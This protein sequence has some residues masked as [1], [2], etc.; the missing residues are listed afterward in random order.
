MGANNI[1]L[2][3]MEA[4]HEQ[5][6][7]FD[8]LD[9][10]FLDKE[11]VDQLNWGEL[12]GACH[13]NELKTYQRLW[14]VLKPADAGNHLEDI[15]DLVEGLRQ[16][17][18]DSAHRIASMSEHR[19]VREHA[20][21]FNG[22]RDLAK[23]VHRNAVAVKSRIQHVHA[24]IHSMVASPH[25]KSML[26]NNVDSR[27]VE[28]FERIPSYQDLFGSLDYLQGGDV[29]SIFSPAAY[30]LDLM[31]IT[32]EYITD[33]NTH[34][35]SDNIQDGYKLQDRR[36]DL[37]EIKLNSKNTNAPLPILQ[38]V[39]SVLER[40]IEQELKV[41]SGVA[42]AGSDSSITLAEDASAVDDAYKDMLIMITGG[43][44][45]AQTR[46]MAGYSGSSKVASVSEKWDVTPDH[47]SRY[48]IA[49]KTYSTLAAA[50]YPFNL[51]FN[52]PLAQI[53]KYLD[54]LEVTLANILE[55]FNAPVTGGFAWGGAETTIILGDNASTVKDYYNTMQLALTGGTGAG[56]IRG[57]TAYNESTREAAV[58]KP[59][60]IK[61]DTTTR[62]QIM[63]RLGSSREYLGLSTEQYRNLITVQDTGEKLGPFFGYQTIDLNTLARVDNFLKRTGLSRDQL[64]ELLTQNLS[65]QEL[66]S[67]LANDFF[68]NKTGEG[69]P[70][71]QIVVDDSDQKNPFYKIA[72][73][74][75]KRLDRLNRFIRL[76]QELNWSFAPLNWAMVSTNA[77]EITEQAI[78]AIAGI[79]R[80]QSSTGLDVEELCAFW[81]DLKTMGKGDGLYPQDLF[82]RVFNS[83]VLLDG[84]DPYTSTDKIPFDT[85]GSRYLT[86]KISD[87]TG[88][89]AIIRGRLLGALR[90][91]NNDLTTM[92]M[93]VLALTG[94]PG[95]SLDLTLSNLTWL[96]RLSKVASIFKMTVDQYLLLLGLIYYP[97]SSYLK[98][99]VHSLGFT[100]DDIIYQRELVDWLNKIPLTLYEILYILK[101]EQSN[102]F[103][104]GY[105]TGDIAPFIENLAVISEGSRLNYNGFIY[106][107]IDAEQS[108]AI[109]KEL[110]DN[111]FLS[112]IG[113]LLDDDNYYQAA[114]LKFPVKEDSFKTRTITGE[115]SKR[116][117]NDLQK[118]QPPV[119]LPQPDRISSTLNHSFDK[120]T[121]LS[122]LFNGVG[123]A[124]N[125]RN[126]VR[127]ILLNIKDRIH[128]AEFAFLYPFDEEIFITNEI[129]KSESI[130]VLQE[131]EGHAPPIIINNGGKLVL[132]AGFDNDI[133]LDFLFA[134][135]GSGQSRTITAYDG[136]TRIAA[137]G[138]NWETIPDTTSIYQVVYTATGTAQ[139]GTNNTITLDANA[140][141]DKDAY[142]G[143][144]I[145]ITDG[146][147]KGQKNKILSYDGTNKVSR[148]TADWTAIP[149]KTSVYIVTG[150]VN[151]GTAQ[152]GDV[153][154]ITL[155]TNASSTGDLYKGMTV[156][157]IKD[158][159]ADLKRGEVKRKLLD[160]RQNITHISDIIDNAGKLQKSNVMQG[161]ASFLS[162]TPEMLAAIIPFAARST[163]ISDY[164]DE[165]LTPIHGGQVPG[166]IPPFLEVL[167]RALV[168]FKK[169]V[170]SID[171]VQ[172]VVD[173][174]GAF[175]IIDT[176]K[177]SLENIKSM[178]D[179]K[180]LTYAFNDQNGALVNYLN[181]P[182]DAVMTGPKVMALATL[183][184]WDTGQ[185]CRLIRLFWP[186][187]EGKSQFD[188]QTIKGLTRLKQC[189]DI[190]ETTGMD[191][192]LLLELMKLGTLPLVDAGNN[193]I[194][195][196]WTTFSNLAGVTLGAVNAKY[197]DER[198]ESVNKEI[199]SYLNTQKRD[200]L[201]G[202]AIWILNKKF[203]VVQK[204]SD[205]YQYLLIDVEMCDCDSVSLIAQGI[206]SVQL[207]MQRCR[208]MLEP[209]VTVLSNIHDVWW[210]WMS[211]YRIWEAN[212]KVFLYPENYIEP[213]L[214]KGRTD[215]F[216][217]FAE[218][219]LQT[220]IDDNTVSD[221]YANYF[222]DLSE[223]ANLV[224][225]AGYNCKVQK[226]GTNETVDTLFIFGRTNTQPYT[227]YF[228][229]FD[230]QYAWSPWRKI[231][232]TINSM[233]ISPVY[234]Y[235]RLFIFWAEVET[236]ASSKVKDNNSV[237]I[238]TSTAKTKYSFL[239]SNGSWA[240]SQTLESGTVVDYRED[241]ER[242][243]YIR[244]LS[245]GI[246]EKYNPENVYWQK[247]YALQIPEKSIKTPDKYPNGENIFVVF[248]FG[249]EF[250]PGF[251]LPQPDPP[252]EKIP[253]NQ[254]SI[255]KNA[256]DLIAR[257]N[258][259]ASTSL[260]GAKGY[261]QG[262]K[263][264]C[265][266]T[267]L[268]VSRLN[269]VI[270]SNVPI[271]NPQPYYPVL[272]RSYT[273]MGINKSPSYN[274]LIDNYYSDDHAQIPLGQSQ[275]ADKI[276]LGNISGQNSS[277]VTV[278][279]FPGS[280]IFDN[281]D[282]AFLVVSQESGIRNISDILSATSKY[283]TFPTNEFYLY[284]DSYTG[285]PVPFDQLTFKFFRISTSVVNKLNQKLFA[286]GI[287]NLLTIESQKTK[288]LLFGRLSPQQT[289]VIAPQS[290]DLDFNGAYGLYFWE[291]FFHGPFLIADTLNINKRFQDAMEWYHYIFNP[292]RQPEAESVDNTRFWRFLPFR[293]LNKETLIQILT[294]PS[295]IKAYNEEPFDPDAIAG[296]RP[297]AYAK[298]VVMKYIDNLLD[299]ADFLF[300]QDTRESINQATNLYVMA[301]DLLGKRPE[302]VGEFPEPESR[303]FNEIKEEYNDKTIA[304]GTAQTGAAMSITL[305]AGA[306][307]EQ[308]A[309]TGMNISITDGMGKGQ[310]AYITSYD[311]T[312]RVAVVEA[313]WQTTP[314]HTSRYKIF[315]NGIPQFLIRLEN[316]GTM[317][318]SQG[319][320][321]TYRPVVFNDLN[322][323]FYIP[324]NSELTEYWDRVDDRLYKIRHGMNIKG[325]VRPL[326]LFEPPVDVRQLILA[327]AGGG[328]SLSLMNR[329]DVQIPNY[330]FPL[331][332]E[333]AKS[334]TSGVMQLGSAL[335]AALEKKDAEALAL[336]RAS[337]EKT[338]LN[339]TTF[340][341]EQQI[342]ELVEIKASLE[343]S[344]KSAT[345][346]S[347]YYTDLLATGLSP[348]E[349]IN[350]VSTTAAMLCNVAAGITRTLASIGYAV[351]QMGSPFA[352]TYGGR[353]IGAALTAAS[354][355]FEIGST[356]SNFVAQLSLTVAGY[357]RRA[358]EW[359]LQA[360][361]AGYDKNQINFQ[362]AANEIRH[363]I[364]KRELEN[365]KTSIQQ[366]GEMEDFLKNKFSNKELYQWMT[367][368]LSTVYFQTYSLAFELAR[369]AQRAYQ[370][371]LNSDQSFVNFGY[372]D[373]LNKGLLA[374]E[375]LMLALN[376]MEKAYLD[377]NS[378]PLEIEKTISL[379]QLNPRAL[380]DLKA[381]GEC[382]F[383]LTEKLFDDDY[384]G[385]YARKIKTV[386]I[387]IP[388]VTGPYQDIKA[389]LTQLSNQII[390]KKD[391]NAVNFLLGGADATTPGADVLRSNWWIN[392]QIAISKGVDDSGVF[393]LN[394]NDERYLPFEGTGAVSSW[395]FRMPKT[396]N[397]FNFDT[398][399]DVLIQLKYT[400]ADGGE[401]FG[402]NV[403]SLDAMKPY[404]GSSCSM[405][406][407]MFSQEWFSFFHEKQN[408]NNQTMEISLANLT[409]P[410][411]KNATLTGFYFNLV[412]PRG[413]KATGNKE[414]IQFKVTDSQ[415]ISFDLDKDNGYMHI[416]QTRPA[417][418]AVEGP[419]SIIFDL[420]KA[421][422]GIKGQSG[423]LDPAVVRNMAL[424][425]FYEGERE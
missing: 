8:L 133:S 87:T 65:R 322:S 243:Q 377:N 360:D 250:S 381:N 93:Y 194:P 238:G 354:G 50:S 152:G 350:I 200:A 236:V 4:F 47:T 135:K 146:T 287:S 41:T 382:V 207:Y 220:N 61:P 95:D 178:W 84:K 412:L 258:D 389:T 284:M 145:E 335:L 292:I 91:S 351:P 223:V 209:G 255:E 172:A 333:K 228:R 321:P 218:S 352:M 214:R 225:C 173:I 116:A 166:I 384:P 169:L 55:A 99:P 159:L 51:P 249:L 344:L 86:W 276:L 148:V 129:T 355:A 277:I 402:K 164:V 330:R 403:K 155:D 73:L 151:Q 113:I 279:N 198:S 83:P 165:F 177:L 233:F 126:E 339:M 132:S 246:P 358:Q 138:S 397:F 143:M 42:R 98:P 184:H 361:L 147:G 304:T 379:M 141:P 59:W 3:G 396:T 68:I 49:N 229:R 244:K 210:E 162:T 120:D 368:R 415:T 327:A 239:N 353:E 72:N 66:K 378:R 182:E 374:G 142:N 400:A 373:N 314:D 60:E 237:S 283:F 115:E 195:A 418:Q 35:Q 413:V 281:G 85:S 392:Q 390:V 411:I 266:D 289:G 318:L 106:G 414:Y 160:I 226:P 16:A 386:S 286:G 295:Q 393:Q 365:H 216:K 371:E 364:C 338:L 171:E 280:F 19:F 305:A 275:T 376:Q 349:I 264:F 188:Y 34:K 123:D 394:F 332:I 7:H 328:G 92:G 43:T 94:Q 291:I 267:N 346:R 196:N 325:E 231:E 370:F 208:M 105:K 114:A 48:T 54:S 117:Y 425:I 316:M 67:N 119:L 64:N 268:N 271:A 331:L 125:K 409:P 217:K 137:I 80:L 189:F 247:V 110:V 131:L 310:L 197:H 163:D 356:I 112:D 296:L 5:N 37:F 11:Q 183:T 424:I 1:R 343:E 40:R 108:K 201:L 347:D 227:Y 56:Q 293:T 282:E 76:A 315:V 174:P 388:A 298:S 181:L 270:M 75:L 274:V 219:L 416:F 253:G 20:C 27:L 70:F 252:P 341:K 30:F 221:A 297:A 300:T 405:L 417:L 149:D 28:Y 387:S 58:N 26:S 269:T 167:S 380:L 265:L 82:D 161:L 77:G 158:P 187:N 23:E 241:Y 33:P 375:G 190:S 340:I 44:G 395:R 273:R 317:L 74:S 78:E 342:N 301:S 180:S 170:F 324:E 199:T 46:T 202:Y 259:M 101:G 423:F 121:D 15:A 307:Q 52:L 256:Y 345:R 401:E 6:P 62:Y 186:E 193:I 153:T 308:D 404:Y 251:K 257:Y 134:S 17:G 90:V 102:Y 89:N 150:V 104:P 10:D 36:P 309:Y 154:H 334:L 206:A 24:N 204:P 136:N 348:G 12:D 13:L 124:D 9:F 32:D 235:N 362:I 406:A 398:I 71:M 337:Q 222:H 319:S 372:W 232:I 212:R 203:D 240:A 407:Q 399:S 144:T 278:K 156:F 326:A 107:D 109:F 369:A 262:L 336:L 357:Q 391:L 45:V 185:I 245:P 248:G 320:G 18:F 29:S 191:I 420:Q 224:H 38:I 127:S 422:S 211:S 128:I 313:P 179:F 53:R 306:S 175:N 302:A 122:F 261:V 242:D 69:L 21:I 359:Q 294:N 79:K 367:S 130:R 31:R 272:N 39:N 103:S 96:Y 363:Q 263:S 303:S 168:L 260:P 14:R 97:D 288:E 366:S 118:S 323:Y 57:I 385:H 215:Q 234:A 22:D 25:F 312:T 157:I 100:V 311:G 421:P 254:F 408:T 140:S 410:H 81:N 2:K 290:D 230:N 329:L 176:T 299:W 383:D 213:A 285:S 139:G 192:Q 419:R 88:Q 111:K 63:D 205:L